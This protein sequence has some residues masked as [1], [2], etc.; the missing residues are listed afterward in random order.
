[1]RIGASVAQGL[2]FGAGID[3]VPVSSMAVVAADAGSPGDTVA[4]AQDAHMNQVYLGLYRVGDDGVP[5][6]LAAERL[7]EI[8]PIDGLDGPAIAAGAGFERYP[9]LLAANRDRLAVPPKVLYPRAGALLELA[10]AALERGAGIAPEALR[11]AY[12]R[13]EVAAKPAPPKP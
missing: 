7:Q 3:V 2:A 4:V 9:E 13:R 12:L 10:A 11:P 6:E 1:M 8:A 5:A